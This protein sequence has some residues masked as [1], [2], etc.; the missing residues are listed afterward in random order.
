MYLPFLDA[1]NSWLLGLRTPQTLGLG[2]V[3]NWVGESGQIQVH[4]CSQTR[5]IGEQGKAP[6]WVTV[7]RREPTS[8]AYSAPFQAVV[9]IVPDIPPSA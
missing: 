5:C 8:V 2:F 4:C 1:E 6:S 3:R 7:S 9:G